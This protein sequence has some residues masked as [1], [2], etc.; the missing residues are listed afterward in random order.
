MNIQDRAMLISL[1]IKS[2]TAT[3]HDKNASREVANTHHSDVT[4]G[5]YNKQLVCKDAMERLKKIQGAARTEHYRRT[6]P[7]AEDG[8]RILSSAGYF[9]YSQAMRK[10]NDEWTDAVREF[11]TD[12]PRFVNEARSRLNGLFRESE[13]PAPFSIES[14]F[15]FGYN[16]FP[17]PSGDDFRV[18][19]GDAE[20]ARIQAEIQANVDATL[21]QAMSDVWDRMKDAVTRMVER[22]RA[23]APSVHGTANPFRDSLVENIRDLV[24]LIPSLNITSDRRISEFSARL[25]NELLQY[26]AQTLRD[27]Q[28]A[29]EETAS[30]AENILTSMRDYI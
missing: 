2:W 15:S 28:Y 29:R 8:S 17:M 20:T 14:K 9:D 18:E 25:E 26:N 21:E 27:N 6:L 1:S 10:F 13:Y 16:V 30:R 23:Y 24:N 22:L 19:L 3:K 7:W 11:V 4:M 12:Y 5:R